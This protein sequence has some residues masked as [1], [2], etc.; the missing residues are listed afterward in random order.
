MLQQFI[1]VLNHTTLFEKNRVSKYMY[2]CIHTHIWLILNKRKMHGFLLEPNA[3]A[4]Q[5]LAHEILRSSVMKTPIKSDSTHDFIKLF[6]HGQLYS[7]NT[8]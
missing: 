2:M 7:S 5:I 3:Q 8:D 6:S 4:L 1:L